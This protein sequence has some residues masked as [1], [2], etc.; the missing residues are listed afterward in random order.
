MNS[1]VSQYILNSTAY[2]NF[3]HDFLRLKYLLCTEP[4]TIEVLRPDLL[5]NHLPLNVAHIYFI[6]TFPTI[7]WLTKTSWFQPGFG[8]CKQKLDKMYLAQGGNKTK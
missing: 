3:S 7:I 2:V 8:E 6:Y 1:H 5:S 4:L